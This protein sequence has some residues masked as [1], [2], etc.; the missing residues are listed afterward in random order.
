MQLFRLE[1]EKMM[2]RQRGAVILLLYF[3][4]EFMLLVV[5]DTPYHAKRQEAG[6]QYRHY[7]S[8]LRGP[9]SKEKA[10]FMEQEAKDMEAAKKTLISLRKAY[11]MGEISEKEYGTKR[12]EANRILQKK[13]GFEAIYEQYL[14]ICEGRKNRYFIEENGWS[15]LLSDSQPDFLLLLTM[16]FLVTPVLCRE[17][18]TQMDVLILTGK[19]GRECRRGKLLLCLSVALLLGVGSSL[20]ELY[21]YSVK[22]GLPNG[23]YPLQSVEYFG[24]S[25]AHLSLWQ[26]WLAGTGMQLAGC[27]LFVL[28]ILLFASLLKKVALTILVVTSTAIL[29]YL[30]VSAS[31]FIRLPLPVSFLMGVDYWK[32]NQYMAEEM[33]GTAILTYKE[34]SER[35]VTFLLAAGILLAVVFVLAIILRNRNRYDGKRRRPFGKKTAVLL[36]SVSVVL[37]SGCSGQDGQSGKGICYNS[38]TSD[39]Y[40]DA[41]HRVYIP[42]DGGR[43]QIEE[44]DGTETELVRDPLSVMEAGVGGS[45]SVENIF[46]DADAFYYT[47]EESE[48]RIDRVGVYN[49]TID[50][51]RVVRVDKKS[52]REEIIFEKETSSGNTVLGIEYSIPNQWR[53]LETCSGFFLNNSFL[54]FIDSDNKIRQV[55]RRTGKL[56]LPGIEQKDGNL[57]FDGEM[58]YYLDDE[59]VLCGYCAANGKTKRYTDSMASSFY[60][61]GTYIYYVNS[62]DDDTIYR[63]D[64]QTDGAEKVLDCPAIDISS[65]NGRLCYTDRK[66]MEE[67][68]WTPQNS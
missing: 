16:L 7:L 44:A 53:F 27:L 33:L 45:A 1:W 6:G 46:G 15:G 22:Y 24:S 23:S 3:V 58:I 50:M 13:E 10:A 5:T 37:L 31:M 12:K 65:E 47:E 41:V 64:L 42:E 55:D 49:S 21:F 60:L 17:Y 2:R 63:L 11:R 54:F 32:G 61:Q 57:A 62:L 25:T 43:P 30:G 67:H 14:Y 4:L 18:E 66:Q 28:E 59:N 39:E 34:V 38:K 40:R 56:T 29:P 8:E 68:E 52:T 48:A 26:A 35:E 51:F 19:Q 36:L 20:L 9:Y